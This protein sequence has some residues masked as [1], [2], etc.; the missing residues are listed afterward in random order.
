MERF[1]FEVPGIARKSEAID[2]IGEFRKFGSDINGTGGLHRYLDNYEGW[3]EKL[4]EDYS[5]KPSAEK[6]PARTFFL[7]RADDNR[8]IGMS[9]I[10]LALNEKLR[11]YGGHIGYSVA[12]SERRKGYAALML[13]RVL[14]K[15]RELGIDKVLITCIS[16]NEGSKR[17]ILKNGG[18]YESS[19]YEPEEGVCLERYWIDLSR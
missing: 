12:P 8:L 2:F 14:P 1:F 4:K 15:C 9:N 7:I 6:V 5:R 13:K 19:V 16:G 11:H 18:V 17:T 10:R 3:L